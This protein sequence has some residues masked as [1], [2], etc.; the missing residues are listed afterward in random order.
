MDL[1]NEIKVGDRV[2]CIKEKDVPNFVGKVWV[3]FD[4]V[5]TLI[6]CQNKQEY[7]SPNTLDVFRKDCFPFQ[8]DE[9]AP[10]TPLMEELL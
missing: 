2:I 9:I 4:I 7:T 5:G 6:Y 1:K 8:R 10:I 3:V